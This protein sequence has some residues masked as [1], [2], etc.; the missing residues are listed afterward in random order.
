MWSHWCHDSSVQVRAG[1]S[2]E[3]SLLWTEVSRKGSM[4]EVGPKDGQD[5]HVAGRER[6]LPDGPDFL[7]QDIVAGMCGG[8]RGRLD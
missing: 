1:E 7:N 2:R 4:E 6:A 5:T 8:H 3:G